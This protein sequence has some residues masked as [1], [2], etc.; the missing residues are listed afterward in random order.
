MAIVPIKFISIIGLT[1]DLDKVVKI[2]GES[3]A[4]HPDEVTSFYSNTKGFV[5]FS[6]KSPYARYL[7]DIK[8]SAEIANIK[9]DLV[10]TSKFK[11]KDNDIFQIE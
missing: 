7:Q 5:P 10:D 6:E 8:Y 3:Q 9:L 2:C 1:S 11:E 4:F